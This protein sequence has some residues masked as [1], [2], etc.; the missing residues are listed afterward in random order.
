MS[1]LTNYAYGLAPVTPWATCT[2]GPAPTFPRLT[3]AVGRLLDQPQQ[4]WQLARPPSYLSR[5]QTGLG[6]AHV[7]QRKISAHIC[8]TW[9]LAEVMQTKQY[10][11]AGGSIVLV[12]CFYVTKCLVG[13]VL[14]IMKQDCSSSLPV[15]RPNYCAGVCVGSSHEGAQDHS[16]CSFLCSAVLSRSR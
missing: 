13:H 7:R 12:S 5:T 16:Y 14:N 15:E 3:S 1:P 4:D 8:T 2:D 6:P 11:I 9:A 10:C